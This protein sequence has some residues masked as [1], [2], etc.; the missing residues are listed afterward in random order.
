MK[1]QNNEKATR[2]RDYEVTTLEKGVMTLTQSSP[3]YLSQVF[4]RL[5]LNCVPLPRPITSSG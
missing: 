1:K 3:S 5:K 2:Q 4:T